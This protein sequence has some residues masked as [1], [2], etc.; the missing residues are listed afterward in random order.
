LVR[1]QIAKCVNGK[2]YVNVLVRI[3]VVVMMMRNH[4][5]IGNNIFWNNPVG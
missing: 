2:N 1:L 5:I 3:A 4:Q